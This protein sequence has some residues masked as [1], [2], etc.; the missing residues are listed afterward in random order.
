MVALL[1]FV[2]RIRAA[3]HAHDGYIK[4]RNETSRFQVQPRR[5]K[6]GIIAGEARASPPTDTPCAPTKA[7]RISLFRLGVRCV[8]WHP[9]TKTLTKHSELCS[10]EEIACIAPC[11]QTLSGLLTRALR[12]IHTALLCHCISQGRPL[13][14]VLTTLPPKA[15]NLTFIICMASVQPLITCIKNIKNTLRKRGEQ[16]S[17]SARHMVCAF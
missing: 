13:H 17:E 10:R 14:K 2:G 4:R 16:F 6:L 5:E 11:R 7:Y 15:N 3:A 9:Q 8:V 12:A 1:W